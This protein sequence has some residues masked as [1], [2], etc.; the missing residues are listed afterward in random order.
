MY[1]VSLGSKS[2]EAF[3]IF[4]GDGKDFEIQS[5]MLV[6]GEMAIW[7]DGNLGR[8]VYTCSI[9]HKVTSLQDMIKD[10]LRVQ[11]ELIAE[12][13]HYIGLLTAKGVLQAGGGESSGTG[14]TED[15]PGSSDAVEAEEASTEEGVEIEEVQEEKGRL[16][17]VFKRK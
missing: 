14:G 12:I 9:S 11:G 6:F 5:T 17:T 16:S 4:W 8:W 10:K 1:R 2:N 3:C 13:Q 15:A 7:G